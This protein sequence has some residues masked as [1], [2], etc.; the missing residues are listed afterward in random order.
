[1]VSIQDLW[2][3]IKKCDQLGGGFNGWCKD[4]VRM[5]WFEQLL[6]PRIYPWIN[7]SWNYQQF[8]KNNYDPRNLGIRKDGNMSALVSNIG[9]LIKQ[10]DSLLMNPNP[11]NSSVS[12]ISDQPKSTNPFKDVYLSLKRQ[13]NELKKSPSAENAQK[14]QALKDALALIEKNRQISAKEYGL[15]VNLDAGYQAPPYSDDFF[16]KPLKGRNSSNYFAQT[17]YCKTKD[18]ESECRSKK[19]NWIGDACY[20]GKYAYLDNSPGLK[21]GYVENMN[22]LI[23]SVINQATQL[24]PNA[25]MGIL[26]GYS[27]PGIDIQQCL[28]ED[29]D[30]TEHFENKKGSI[31]WNRLLFAVCIFIGIIATLYI[32]KK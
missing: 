17:G 5:R 11:D 1:M 13:I 14:I 6:G 25:Y 16:N 31:S 8:V 24:N 18:S 2:N 15:G 32:I 29:D 20:K 23:P 3:E 12:G 19:L 4:Q 28:D 9:I 22:G 26:R 30:E 21:I 7:L 27:V 10:L